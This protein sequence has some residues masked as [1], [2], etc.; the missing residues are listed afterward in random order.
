M[1]KLAVLA[2][3]VM[4]GA[5]AHAAMVSWSVDY[6]YIGGTTTAA[7]GWQ[8]VFF[9]N[10]EVARATFIANLATDSYKND[11]STY[12]GLGAD[13]TDEDGYTYGVSKTTTY[14][15]PETITGYLVLFDS[16]DYAN[17]TKAYVS[18]TMDATTGAT[19]GQN[20][21]MDFGD[22][23]GSQLAANWSD[24]GGGA[25]VPEP[26]SGLLLLLGVASLALK[27][28]RA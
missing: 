15:N 18:E 24:I 19:A 2:A 1:K 23:T 25:A 6:S 9:D 8:V 27:R 14:G 10:A 4:L 11:V 20:A 5:F 3:G 16:D 21:A 28:K 17:A 26:T 12:G 7:E 22:L 13:L